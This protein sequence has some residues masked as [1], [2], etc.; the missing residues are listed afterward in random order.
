M[1]KMFST[2]C[3]IVCVYLTMC[4]FFQCSIE[5]FHFACVGLTTKP[6]GKWY[7]NDSHLKIKSVV[8]HQSLSPDFIFH[9]WS[10]GIVHGACKTERGNKGSSKKGTSIRWKIEKKNPFHQFLKY[11]VSHFLTFGA[12]TFGLH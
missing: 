9:I 7:E 2:V 10:P 11:F 8:S 6:R 3:V 1:D 5:W 12:F 4:V